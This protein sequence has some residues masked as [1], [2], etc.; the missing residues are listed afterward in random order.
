[1]QLAGRVALVTGAGGGIGRATARLF[2]DRGAR[3]IATDIDE[4]GL[5][6]TADGYGDAMVAC[7]ADATSADDAARAV[8]L[9]GERFGAL[10]LLV[11][12]VGGSRPGKTVTDFALDE[13]DFWIRLNLTSTFLMCRAAI[14]AIAAA[15]GGAIVN[16]A[17]GAGVT[18]M[19]RNPAYVAAKGGVI[20]LTRSLAIDHAAQGIR[21]NAIA[22]GPILTPLMKRNR[23]EPEI[24]FMSKLSLAGRL[25]KPEEIAS[26]AAFLCSDDGAY[27]NGELINVGGGRGGPI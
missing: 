18:G 22:P 27:V 24:A 21:A 4:A 13:W 6:E 14:P 7:P 3:V 9:A 15:G 17:S 10:H 12:N 2:A 5:T 8:A 16:V 19:G 26:T 20:S 1:M 11:N 25:G 23:S